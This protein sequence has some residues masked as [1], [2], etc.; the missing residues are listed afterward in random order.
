MGHSFATAL[1]CMDGRIQ[2]PV[3]LYL[4]DRLGVE[5][6]DTITEAGIVRFFSGETDSSQ[7]EA[8]LSSIRISLDKHGSRQIAIAAHDDC[9]ANPIQVHEQQAQVIEGV[10]FLKNRFPQCDIFGLW[11]DDAR[12]VHEITPGWAAGK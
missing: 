10:A 11:V 1:N 4:L 7:T 6:I 3:T 9:A 2:L 12:K 5:Y 8:A